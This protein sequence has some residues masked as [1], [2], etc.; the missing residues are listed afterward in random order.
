MTLTP[1]FEQQSN[2]ALEGKSDLTGRF[3]RMFIINKHSVRH[4]LLTQHNDFDLPCIKQV[5][6]GRQRRG[7]DYLN[8]LDM[9]LPYKKINGWCI[10]CTKTQAVHNY[11]VINLAGD[12]DIAVQR[13]Q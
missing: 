3:P 1:S 2:S 12:K 9:A 8:Y 7:Y 13:Q 10:V 5:R 6:P 4:L 11:F